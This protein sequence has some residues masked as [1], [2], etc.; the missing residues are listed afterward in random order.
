MNKRIL[1][2]SFDT[3]LI[4]FNTKADY[5]ILENTYNESKFVERSNPKTGINGLIPLVE[6]AISSAF[7]YRKIKR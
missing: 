4:P 1:L 2:Q 6:L 5:D 7:A 3:S